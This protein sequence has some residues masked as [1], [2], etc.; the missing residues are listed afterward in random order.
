[1]KPAKNTGELLFRIEGKV[2]VR[3]GPD[4]AEVTSIIPYLQ[5]MGSEINP[6]RVSQYYQLSQWSVLLS[7]VKYSAEHHSWKVDLQFGRFLQ[8]LDSLVS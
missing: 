6:F 5:C 7:K 4:S 2:P 3:F 1:M 8:Q